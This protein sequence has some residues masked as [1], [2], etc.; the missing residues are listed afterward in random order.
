VIAERGAS[1]SAIVTTSVCFP[2]ISPGIIADA[3]L[4]P[5]SVTDLIVSPYPSTVMSSVAARY[6]KF[7]RV[8]LPL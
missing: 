8:L 6:L 4:F 5:S 2:V 7:V 1:L 3:I